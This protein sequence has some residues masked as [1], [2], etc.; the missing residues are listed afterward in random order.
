MA[1]NAGVF[2]GILVPVTADGVLSF[3]DGAFL[4]GTTGDVP[5]VLNKCAASSSCLASSVINNGAPRVPCIASSAGAFGDTL[6]TPWSAGAGDTLVCILV[7]GGV[8]SCPW[9]FE[10]A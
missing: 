8:A 7:V 10:C 2:G 9:Q 5:L 6:V 4:A 3:D 1:G